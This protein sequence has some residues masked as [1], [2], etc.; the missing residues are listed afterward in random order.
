MH[1]YFTTCK[2]QQND[3]PSDF[4]CFSISDHHAPAACILVL[5]MF[6]ARNGTI[7]LLTRTSSFTFTQRSFA[8]T[9]A[10]PT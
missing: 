4:V 7:N 1:E 9:G 2:L 3:W 8:T 5:L 10:C 6:T